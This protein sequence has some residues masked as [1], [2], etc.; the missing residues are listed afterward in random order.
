[1]QGH[2]P[3]YLEHDFSVTRWHGGIFRD[4]I[5]LLQGLNLPLLPMSAGANNKKHE[6]K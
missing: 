1:M 4:Q 5:P 3:L 6:E 2:G